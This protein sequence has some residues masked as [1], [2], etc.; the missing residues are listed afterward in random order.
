[1]PVVRVVPGEEGGAGGAAD[2]RV[3]EEVGQPRASAL[4]EV[5]REGH[6]RHASQEE[7]LVVREQE[8]DV[9]GLGAANGGRDGQE[10]ELEERE[11]RHRAS[12]ELDDEEGWGRAR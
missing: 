5:S 9:R 1:M 10:S 2:G 4:H 3:H 7:V 11:R 8:D 6:R 12:C